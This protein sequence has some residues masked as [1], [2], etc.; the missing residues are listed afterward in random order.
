MCKVARSK[1]LTLQ[2][3]NFPN[4]H[5]NSVRTVSRA[6]RNLRKIP[7]PGTL[8]KNFPLLCKLVVSATSTAIEYPCINP[9]ASNPHYHTYE[10]FTQ[11]QAAMFTLAE[12]LANNK[13]E[14]LCAKTVRYI[15]HSDNFQ[16]TNS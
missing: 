14:D 12:R 8:S 15:G 1:P 3:F 10:A 5:T 7:F 4:R 13:R 9:P 2:I 16:Q 11:T 6:S